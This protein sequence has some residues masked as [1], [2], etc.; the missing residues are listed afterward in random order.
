MKQTVFISFYYRLIIRSRAAMLVCT[1]LAAAMMAHGASI[2]PMIKPDRLLQ[3]IP[4]LHIKGKVIDASTREPLPG[5]S[6]VIQGTSQGSVTNENGVF[7]LSDVPGDAVLVFTFVGYAKQIE[8]LKGRSNIMIALKPSVNQ[9]NEAVVVGYGTVVKKDLTG[10]VGQVDMADM[11]KA[12]V[13]SFDEALA[14]R[15]AGVQVS[16][17][18]GQ[19]GAAVNIV[20]RGNNSLTQDNSPLYVI[21][22]FPVEDPDNSELDPD[23]IETISVLKDASATA[24]YGARAANGVI[25]ITTKRGKEGPPRIS[26]NGYYGIQQVIHEMP[27]MDPYEFMKLQNEITTPNVL[28]EDGYIDTTAGHVKTIDDY[29]NAQNIDW[30]GKLFRTA[31]MQNHSLSIRGGSQNTRYSVSGQLFDQKGVLINSGFRRAQAKM[32][33]DQTV[34]DKLRVGGDVSYTSTLTYGTTPSSAEN[35]TSSMTNLMY[36]VWGYRPVVPLGD[37]ASSL[38]DD[39]LDDFV[40]PTTDYRFNP[41]KTAE[42]QLRKH[43]NHYIRINGYA[44]YQILKD[45]TLRITGGFS[46]TLKRYDSFNNSD[47]WS[48]SK[49]NIYGVNGSI[50]YYETQQWLNENTLTYNKQINKYN[51]IKILGGATFQGNKYN[52]YG[53]SANHLPNESLGLSGLDEGTPQPVKALTEA[54]TLASFLGRINYT[55]KDKYLLTA[56]LRADGSSKF[57]LDNKWSYFPSAAFAWRLINESF[58]KNIKLLSDAKLRVSWGLTGNNRVSDYATYAQLGFPMTAYYSFDDALA[59]GAIPEGLASEDL[60]WESTSQTDVGLDVGF[61]NERITLT[62]DYYKK[63]TSRLLLNAKLPPTTGYSSAYKNIGKVSNEGLELSLH[64]VNVQ[65][66]KFTWSTGFTISFNKSKVLELTQNQESLESFMSWDQWYNNTSLYIAKLDQPMGQVYGYIYDGLYQY[67]DFNKQSDGSYVLKPGEPVQSGQK[68]S[69]VQPGDAK[70]RDLNGDGIVNDYDRTVIGR[71]F[72]IHQG[73]FTNDF[74]YGNFDLNLFFQW[75]YG[76][77]IINANRLVFE[78]GNKLYLNQFKSFEKR[79]EP[80]H[81]NTD[82]P[83]AGGQ[84]GY[85]YSS[86]VV[87]DGSYLRLKTVS[88]GYKLP[89]RLLKRTGIYSCRFY[90]S[91]QNLITWTGYTGSDPEVSIHYSALTPGFDYSAYPRPRTMVVGVKLSL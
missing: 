70:Y 73:G 24:I 71:G 45:L 67:D 87:E 28:Q 15:V 37:T 4:P 2:L 9:L 86:R 48:G 6:V 68:A 20:I 33:L 78:M 72:P 75:S 23:N 60:K 55:Y 40:N 12:P 49:Y 91:A 85:V 22:G 1:L 63:T 52:Y 3:Q 80:D 79:W 54:W 36:S 82:I 57:Q 53:A 77:D 62:A 34:N 89:T 84:F 11:D 43:I 46:R 35:G 29:K 50:T 31:P 83:R 18:D 90:L 51:K 65:T 21:D 17:T 42:N 26:Y 58:L 61:F 76:N 14:G 88:L 13:A 66:K 44:D 64:T 19:P 47:T 56:S 16:S 39:L 59:Q 74:R 5:V 10:S 25:I 30:Q 27:L 38:Q 41:I 8:P 81:T 32:S 69:Q 7:E